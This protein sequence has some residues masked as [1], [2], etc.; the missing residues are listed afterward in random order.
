MTIPPPPPNSRRNVDVS[1]TTDNE[2]VNLPGKTTAQRSIP[3]PDSSNF[4]HFPLSS[5]PGLANAHSVVKRQS[6][7]SSNRL[8]VSERFP[9]IEKKKENI[10][11]SFLFYELRFLSLR[12][13]VTQ[14]VVSL[15]FSHSVNYGQV[16]FI[17]HTHRQIPRKK[18]QKCTNSYFFLRSPPRARTTCPSVAT[19]SSP[20]RLSSTTRSW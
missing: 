6:G 18:N 16:M 15:K 3:F 7:L 2:S 14:I 8:Q 1:Q 4:F 20:A 12:R 9:G 19:C 17:S 11:T 13:K 10:S 5:F